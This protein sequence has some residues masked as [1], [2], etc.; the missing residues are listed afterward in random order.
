MSYAK[1]AE[2][3]DSMAS[4]RRLDAQCAT[5]LAVVSIFQDEAP[6]LRE[7]IE[8][9]RM[10]GVQRFVLVN[11]R[12]T[13]NF[14]EVLEPY[15]RAGIVRLLS[16]PCPVRF[17]GKHWIHFQQKVLHACVEQLRGLSR[18]VALIDIDE[19]VVPETGSVLDFVR[20][21]EDVGGVYIRWEPFGT[22]Y[23]ERLSSSDLVIERLHLKWR[24]IP[25]ADMLGKSIV[26][27]HRVARANIH[28]CELLDGFE[29]LDANP[30]MAN[31]DAAIRINH[32]WSRDE[33]FLLQRKLP[34]SCRIKGWTMDEKLTNF[35]RSCFNEV[36][37]HGMRRFVPALRRRLAQEPSSDCSPTS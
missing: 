6:F 16:H 17:Q 23:V 21:R 30:G 19:F 4:D 29:Y 31:A 25:G 10:M 14:E 13:D 7:W 26:K 27:P 18:W 35:Y 3:G 22:S 32:Y 28:R 12:S 24:F 34:R 5:E 11:D 9:H 20:A 15:Q 37:D 36:P 1:P 8:F 2:H 33:H